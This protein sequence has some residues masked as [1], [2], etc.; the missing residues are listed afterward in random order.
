M[1]QYCVLEVWQLTQL[2]MLPHRVVAYLRTRVT[3]ASMT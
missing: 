2:G 3:R 1:Y